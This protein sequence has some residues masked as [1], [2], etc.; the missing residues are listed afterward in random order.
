MGIKSRERI[1]SGF[2][3][4]KMTGEHAK[5]YEKLSRR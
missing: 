1:E 4:D 3:I 2:N 5:L